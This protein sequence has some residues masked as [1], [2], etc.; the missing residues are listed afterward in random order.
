[1]TNDRDYQYMLDNFIEFPSELSDTQPIGHSVLLPLAQVNVNL[2]HSSITGNMEPPA[3]A[4]FDGS[5]A[6]S[7]HPGLLSQ[8]TDM[9]SALKKFQGETS[10]TVAM[11]TYG[12]ETS[13]HPQ[14]SQQ[15]NALSQPFPLSGSNTIFSQQEA[16]HPVPRS[17]SPYFQGPPTLHT[18]LSGQIQIVSYS[19]VTRHTIL[20]SQLG[21]T[22]YHFQLPECKSY[23]N[24]TRISSSFPE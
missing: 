11:N 1:M 14:Y 4:F 15:L 21:P 2:V 23:T 19:P 20:T 8:S 16:R 9:V 17:Y 24:C 3:A 13:R 5:S 7:I 12:I 22:L 18:T 6:V 10:P